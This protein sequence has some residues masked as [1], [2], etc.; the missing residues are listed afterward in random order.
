MS[1][2]KQD[3]L[4]FLAIQRASVLRIVADLS[5]TAWHTPLFPS[6]WTAAGLLEHL[7][8]AEGH[9]LQG[10]V[11]D[12]V[13]A[14]PYDE[15]RPPWTPDIVYTTHHTGA[16]VARYYR[17][18]CACGD[19]IL[20]DLLPDSPLRG[21]HGDPDYPEFETVRQV[22][23]HLIEETATHSGHLDIARELLDGRTNLGDR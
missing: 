10:V 1:A 22:V 9:W 16:E 6:G 12:T 14:L 2:E 4:Q 3:L 13:T 5:E 18:Q 19:A 15:G 7:G 23:L 17:D 21:R 8:D 20:A 11:A